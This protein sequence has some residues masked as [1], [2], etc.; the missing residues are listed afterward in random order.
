MRSSVSVGSCGC[1]P[2]GTGPPG[3]YP[4]FGAVTNML[5]SVI[6]TRCW[7]KLTPTARPDWS[8]DTFRPTWNESAL[9]ELAL[10]DL[11]PAAPSTWRL[12]TCN[13]FVES[14]SNTSPLG[15]TESRALP[16]CAYQ[17]HPPASGF[18]SLNIN[19]ALDPL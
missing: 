13:P 16:F 19:P 18:R 6:C 10:T 7:F 1:G 2:P 11:A 15:S 17:L 4:A 9:T 8:S 3:A 5:E 14:T 12:P